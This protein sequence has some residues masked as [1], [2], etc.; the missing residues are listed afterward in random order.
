VVKYERGLNES[1]PRLLDVA[2]P[3]LDS[4]KKGWLISVTRKGPEQIFESD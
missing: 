2:D 1:R 4:L 3:W